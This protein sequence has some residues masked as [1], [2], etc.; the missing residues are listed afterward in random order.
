M[1]AT[2]GLYEREEEKSTDG[3]TEISN[4]Q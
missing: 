4:E 2:Y 1:Y 3:H